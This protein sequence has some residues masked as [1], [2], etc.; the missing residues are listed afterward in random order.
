[1]YKCLQWTNPSKSH[2]GLLSITMH[3]GLQFYERLRGLH[4]SPLKL[5]LLCNVKY[6]RYTFVFSSSHSGFCFSNRQCITLDVA[7]FATDWAKNKYS[8]SS[9][10]LKGLMSV[11]PLMLEIP[12]HKAKADP[13]CWAP[14]KKHLK[15]WAVTNTFREKE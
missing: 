12:Q 11:H 2:L 3:H 1:M 13:S 14:P 15:G 10:F 8:S 6:F 4:S 5:K 9:L 7:Y